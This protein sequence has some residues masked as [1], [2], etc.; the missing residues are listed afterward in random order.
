[1]IKLRP[2]HVILLAEAALAIGAAIGLWFAWQH[3]RQLRY[4]AIAAQHTIENIPQQ[5]LQQEEV[6]AQLQQQDTRLRPIENYLPRREAIGDV[7]AAIESVARKNNV[8]VIVPEITD[9]VRLDSNRKPIPQ[10]GRYR[11]VQLVVQAYGDPVQLLTFLHGVEHLPYVVK[12]P[13][14]ELTTDYAALPTALSVSLPTT[15]PAPD[16]PAGFLEAGVVLTITRDQP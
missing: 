14:F 10:A 6:A 9:D 15:T 3:L 7:V 11:D 4:Q 12:V 2:Q 16:S 13:D 5:R 8:T 1:M